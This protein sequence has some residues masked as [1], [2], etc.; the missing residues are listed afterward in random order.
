MSNQDDIREFSR[1]VRR[2]A[3]ATGVAKK[4]LLAGATAAT[5]T[6]LALIDPEHEKT[7][8]AALGQDLATEG[9]AAATHASRKTVFA[10]G[11]GRTK[12]STA[13]LNHNAKNLL[14]T[15]QQAFSHD[16]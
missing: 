10:G 8:R 12:I 11:E 5:L 1:W 14:I 4:P 13:V 16:L 3:R 15:T 2:F 7:S 9:A 6:T